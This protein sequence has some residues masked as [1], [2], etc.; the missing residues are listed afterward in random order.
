MANISSGTVSALFKSRNNILQLLSRQGMDVSNYTDYGVAEVQTM[1][2][3]NQLDMLLTTEKDIHPARKVYVKYYLAKTLRRE[4][5]NNMIDDLFYIEQVLMPTDTL[6]IVMKQE[7]ND[8]VIGILNEIWE[9]D[10]IFIVVQS[11]DRLQFNILEHQYVPEHV[12]LTEAEQEEVLK[13]YN[14]TDT[15]Q[16]PSISRYDP[17]A[18]AIGLRPGQ[19]CR[20][21]RSSKTS[22][23]T[24]FYRYCVPS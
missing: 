14:I 20:I 18:L 10:R 17:V 8:T 13:K 4:N 22:V 7:V 21:T 11:L 23:T 5:I 19:I 15:K 12:V 9:K 3:N 16:M 6:I 24:Y 2:A 1:Y